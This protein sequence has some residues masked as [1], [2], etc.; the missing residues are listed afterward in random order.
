MDAPLPENASERRRLRHRE[1]A[2]RAILDATEELIVEQGFDA[3][4]MRRLV[5]R[6]GYTAPT[7]YHYFGD[8]KG[9]LDTL[10]EERFRRMVETLHRVRRSQDPVETLLAL[11]ER[12]V[13]FGVRNPSSAAL[14]TALRPDPSDPPQSSVEARA[15]I[16]APLALLESQG[17]L[18]ARDTEEAFQ[19]LWMVMHGVMS[20]LTTRPDYAWSKSLVRTSLEAMLRGLVRDAEPA[21][22]RARRAT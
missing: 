19:C 5:D 11:A 3:F 21:V 20:M 4:S 17:R 12:C 15:L 22:A 18:R 2:R 7:I 9:L 1:D 6:C 16:E 8:K 14:L 13:R 10:L